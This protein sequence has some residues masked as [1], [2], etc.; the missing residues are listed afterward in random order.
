MKTRNLATV[1]ILACSFLLAPGMVRAQDNDWYQGRRGRWVQEQNA[2]QFH[3]ANG[4]EYRQQNGSWGWSHPNHPNVQAVGPEAWY[5]GQRGHWIKYPSGW[6]FRTD[7]G[8]V[9][10]QLNGSW[11]WSEARGR[12]PGD[13]R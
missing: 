12:G 11:G 3:D 4:E 7:N 1:V 5:Q 2:W 8:R 10:Q 13:Y 9:Y 6:R